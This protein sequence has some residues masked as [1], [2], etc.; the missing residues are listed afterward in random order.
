M[1]TPGHS[2]GHICLYSPS[3]RLMFSGDH[4]LP[5]ISPNIS[6]HD[7]SAPNPLADYLNS[8]AKVEKLECD[9][10]LPGHE[11]RFSGLNE[12]VKELR[13]HH[14]AR[15]GE[16]RMVLS[17]DEY[18]TCWELATHLTWSRA[19]DESSPFIMRTSSGETLAHLAYLEN[20]GIVLRTIERPARFRLAR[21][22]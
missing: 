13:S 12:R 7:S 8:L 20:V 11:W 6:F 19:L 4:V 17:E 15:L 21:H 14:D 2:P 9:E 16:V 5:R 1:W 3:R 18:M 10:V 22:P